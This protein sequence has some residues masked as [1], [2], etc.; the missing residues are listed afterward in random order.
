MRNVLEIE[1]AIEKLPREDHRNLHG[2]IENYGLEH[3]GTAAS[4]QIAAVLD[5]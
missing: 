1:K 5:D 2:R 4:A 3:D